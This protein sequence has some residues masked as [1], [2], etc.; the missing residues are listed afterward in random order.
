MVSAAGKVASEDIT[1][2]MLIRE[3]KK[4]KRI[5][6]EYVTYHNTMTA[7]AAIIIDSFPDVFYK[8]LHH[9]DLG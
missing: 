4:W 7:L 9:P 6:N 2:V 5:T 1:E 3:E 8:V